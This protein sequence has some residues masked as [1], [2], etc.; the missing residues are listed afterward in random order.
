MNDANDKIKSHEF[1]VLGFV[2]KTIKEWKTISVFVVIFSIIGVVVALN[3][4]KRYTTSVVL[5]PEMGGGVDGALSSVSS[6]FGINLSSSSGSDAISPELYPNVF[7]STI[8]LVDLFDVPVTLSETGEKKSYYNHLLYD[9]NIP[10]WS[11]PGIWL[12]KLM[13]TFFKKDEIPVSGASTSK[14]FHLTKEQD[15]ACGIMKQNIFCVVDQRTNIITVSVTDMDPVIAATMADTVTLRLQN[16]ITDYRTK[17]VRH[18]LEYIDELYEQAKAE[19]L[20]AQEEY[21][22][23]TDAN[24]KVVRSIY[25]AKIDNLENDMQLK[26]SIFTDIA[27][28]KQLAMQ[29]VQERTPAFTVI[30]P[31]TVSLQAS[32]MPRSYMVIMFAMLGGCIGVLWTQYLRDVY[33]KYRIKK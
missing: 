30:Q 31:A 33:R 25:R 8:F 21:V 10:F 15:G 5:A 22:K 27:K 20:V 17:K 18:D 19:Y 16:Y 24:A 26:L 3:T 2:R 7:A 11:Y 4:S 23:S 29:R 32:S 13:K 14:Y 9:V 6:M 28:Q 12:G 1:D